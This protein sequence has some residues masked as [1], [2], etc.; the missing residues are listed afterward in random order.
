MGIKIPLIR[1]AGSAV[2]PLWVLLPLAKN[3]AKYST[4]YTNWY[5]SYEIRGDE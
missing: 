1:Q 4:K 3:W 2:R 5:I